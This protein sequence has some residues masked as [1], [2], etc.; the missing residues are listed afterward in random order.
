MFK[1]SH[2]DKILR[3]INILDLDINNIMH[4]DD[5]N[6]FDRYF[7]I[8]RNPSLDIISNNKKENI[9]ENCK[10]ISEGGENLDEKPDLDMNDLINLYDRKYKENNIKILC[11]KYT[12]LTQSLNIPKENNNS[13]KNEELY[14]HKNNISNDNIRIKFNGK[15][16]NRENIY[17]TD[18]IYK[19]LY[20]NKHKKRRSNSKTSFYNS[21]IIANIKHDNEDILDLKEI[22]NI[23]CNLDEIKTKKSILYDCDYLDQGIDNKNIYKRKIV[24]KISKYDLRSNNYF[25]IRKESHLNNI[26][27]KSKSNRSKIERVYKEDSKYKRIKH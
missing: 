17:A 1:V 15:N 12:P 22:E 20:K 5:S 4:R 7:L 13:Y 27:Y 16:Y 2:K 25:E 18:N 8:K 3:K 11:D 23:I 9:N 6:Q 10:F 26:S 24:N 19:S 21:S 14:F